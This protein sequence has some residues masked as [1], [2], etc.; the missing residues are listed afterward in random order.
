MEL[1]GKLSEL[2]GFAA[3]N[4]EMED[5]VA[6]CEYIGLVS[7]LKKIFNSDTDDIERF[8]STLSALS[9]VCGKYDG[10]AETI[11][12][13]LELMDEYCTPVLKKVENTY[14]VR[15]LADY[16]IDENQCP[17]IGDQNK[18]VTN[19]TLAEMADNYDEVVKKLRQHYIGIAYNKSVQYDNL[20]EKEQKKIDKHV[21]TF[22][23]AKIELYKENYTSF[24]EY[25]KVNK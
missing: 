12:T 10:G 4:D 25:I 13:M 19:L 20:S 24:E 1:I 9:T 3:I 7:D 21:G 23:N 6:V 17:K 11:G 16:V 8:Q 22:I 5:A 18:L 15:E 2:G 14:K